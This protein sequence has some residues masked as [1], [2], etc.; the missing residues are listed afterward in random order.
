ME[1]KRLGRVK[2]NRL[3]GWDSQLTKLGA[4]RKKVG[5]GR[6]C[7]FWL[8]EECAA[9]PQRGGPTPSTHKEIHETFHLEQMLVMELA[10]LD[11]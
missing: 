2:E 10:P 3:V 6:D 5:G 1:Y 11:T 9:V 4:G 7:T 8:K